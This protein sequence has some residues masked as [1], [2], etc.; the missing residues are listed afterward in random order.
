MA[1]AKMQARVAISRNGPYIVTGGVPLSTQSIGAGA[2]GDS[3]AWKE[4]GSFPQAEQYALCR[5]G[6][7]NKKPFCDGTHTRI[8]FDGSETANRAPYLEQ[9]KAIEGPAVMLTDVES[10]CAF[11]RFCDPNGKVWAQVSHTDDPEVRATFLRQV[12]DCPS[13]RL[14]AWD[15]ASREPLQGELPVSIGLIE[16]PE[17]DCSGPIWLRGGIALIA[18]DGFEYEP[19]NRVTLCRCGRS[20]NKPFCDGAHAAVK[21]HSDT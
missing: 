20:A 7:S 5:C 15:K 2:N 8:G 10:F 19:R 21:F 17:E 18:A 9:A 6:E 1:D 16:D 14:L 11:A 3:T 4:S 13:G 12:N